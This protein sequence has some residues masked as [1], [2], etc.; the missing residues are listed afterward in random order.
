MNLIKTYLLNK[1]LRILSVFLEM[2]GDF[3]MNYIPQ[4][5]KNVN[6][7]ILNKEIIQKYFESHIAFLDL[8]SVLI[9]K[10]GSRLYSLIEEAIFSFIL[11][12]TFDIYTSFIERNDRTVIKSDK[13]YTVKLN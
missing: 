6:N 5:K 3:L 4:I 10:F 9:N 7:A 13:K 8:M 12:N 1:S 2:Y 11:P